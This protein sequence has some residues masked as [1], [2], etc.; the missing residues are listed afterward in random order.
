MGSGLPADLCVASAPASGALKLHSAQVCLKRMVGAADVPACE[1]EMKECDQAASPVSSSVILQYV[2]LRTCGTKEGD[3]GSATYCSDPVLCNP[4][5]SWL[6]RS[7]SLDSDDGGL[8]IMPLKPG[9]L[10]MQTRV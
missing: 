3:N 6:P 2:P 5:M 7:G 9:L 4:A 10:C 1:N 8:L